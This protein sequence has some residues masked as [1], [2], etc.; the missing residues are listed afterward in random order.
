MCRWFL[1][2]TVLA[3]VAVS[4]GP[5]HIAPFKPRQRKLDVGEYAADRA[6]AR[7]TPGSLFTEA[8]PGFLQDARALRVGDILFIKID[9]A[10]NARGD[11]TTK[12]NRDLNHDVNVKAIF[13][14]VPAIQE[15]HPDIKPEELLSI[16][17][18]S[19]FAGEGK[20][21]RKGELSGAIAVRVR[22]VMPNGDLF[23]EG[24]K[25]V[26]INNEENHLYVSGL[27]RTTDIGPDNSVSSV[28]LA[29]AQVEFTGRGDVADQVKRGWLM[30]ALDA[31]N[32][33]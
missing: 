4:C 3:W 19:D 7:P 20:T 31:V 32:P 33:F 12:L 2:P 28:R 25:V 17:T 16:L 26:M 6:D 27:V 9:E 29:E 30:K 5:A 22:E 15:Q 21:S 13:G 18:N 14:L 24:T 23:I 11:A 10:T 1:V 8:V